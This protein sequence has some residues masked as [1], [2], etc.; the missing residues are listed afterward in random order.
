[1]TTSKAIAANFAQ[2][3]VCEVSC[4][5]LFPY[6]LIIG[7]TAKGGSMAPN[8]LKGSFSE[9]S[10]RTAAFSI[11]EDNGSITPNFPNGFRRFLIKNLVL[12]NLPIL[13]PNAN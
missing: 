12:S 8:L 5:W 13:P 6:L 7:I 2:E 1:M 10:G 3:L 11:L 4:D 9:N